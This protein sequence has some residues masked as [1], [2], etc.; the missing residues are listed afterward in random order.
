MVNMS[1]CDLIIFDIDGTLTRSKSLI[2]KEMVGLICQLLEKYKVAII[3]GAGYGQFQWQIL[4]QLSCPQELLK[5]LYLL[6]VDGTV[7]CFD[8]GSWR[9]EADEELSEQE[10]SEIRKAFDQALE[11][12]GISKPEKIEGDLVEDR[13]SQ[14]NFSALGQKAAVEPKEKW[15]P[16]NS[17]RIRIVEILKELLPNFAFHIG[18]TTSIEVT[19]PGVDKA[20]GLRKFSQSS[21][22]TFDKMLYFGDKLFE[23]GNDA[24][25][26]TLGIECLAVKGPEETK[27]AIRELL[28]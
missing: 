19:R 24:P 8:E 22:I 13:G 21:G 10:K 11:K 3:S 25:V 20:Y 17:K 9:C 14:M 18:G 6:P 1:K 23:G 4:D 27:V 15:D 26:L 7:M 16:D 28:E 12:T 2:D 5:K